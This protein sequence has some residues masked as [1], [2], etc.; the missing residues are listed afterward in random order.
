MYI[1]F[2]ANKNYSCWSL[3]PW[4]LMQQLALPF[5]ERMH[6]FGSASFRNF[7][8]SDLRSLPWISP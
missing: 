2:I 1:L 8:P 4:L 6:T 7:S 3:R 5:V